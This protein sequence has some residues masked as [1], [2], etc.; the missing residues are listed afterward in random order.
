MQ[1][2]ARL[3][4]RVL[5]ENYNLINEFE[6]LCDGFTFVDSWNDNKITPETFRIYAR[7]IPAK[8]ASRNF[9]ESVKRVY[10]ASE[11]KLR[12][13]HDLHRRRFSHQEWSLASQAVN[14]FLDSNTKEQETLCFFKGA[15]FQCTYNNDGYFSQSQLA[16]CYD[17]P[18]NADLDAFK[19]SSYWFS[20][21]MSSM[22][23]LHLI[24]MFQNNITWTLD[25]VRL[26]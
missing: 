4:Y 7:N 3:D 6:Q 17:L 24:I 8:E 26:I 12:K 15:I 23:H 13:S 9:V 5:K 2:I 16:L 18:N 25:F 11:I 10:A 19:K 20:H 1:Q 21:H 14:T 22:I